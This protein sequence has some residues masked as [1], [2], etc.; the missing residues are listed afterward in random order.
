ME[1]DCR[2]VHDQ[3][4]EFHF[5]WL[6]ILIFFIAWEIPE[7]VTFPDIEPFEPLAMKF[8]TLRYLSDM[9]KKW[10]SNV[11]FHAYYNKLNIAIQSTSCIT[12]NNLYRF[13]PLMNFSADRQF[14]YITACDDDH[15][16]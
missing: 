4:Y 12:P 8:S 13:R 14:I 15:K 3:G 11:F 1:F 2:E 7:G 16:Q 9:N 10:K 6:L 5:R